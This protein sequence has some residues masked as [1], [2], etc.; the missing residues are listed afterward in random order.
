VTRNQAHPLTRRALVALALVSAL[1]ATACREG[2]SSTASAAPTPSSAATVSS[3]EGPKAGAKSNRQ[4]ALARSPGESAIDKEI[5]ALQQALE[6]GNETPDRWIVL[7]RAWVRKAREAADPGF[8]LNAKACADIALD[9]APGDRAAQNLVGLVLLNNHK[10]AEARDLADELLAKNGDDLIALGSLSDA[11]LELGHVAEAVRAADRMMN[12]KPNNP[13]Y[14]RVSF[15]KWVQGDVPGALEAIR[16]AIDSAHGAKDKEPEAWALVQ[17]AM[18]WW[19]KGDYSGA[20]KGFEAAL[21]V[22][23]DYPPALVGRGRVAMAQGDAK[24]AADLLAR[25]YAASPL[26]ETAWLLGDAREAAG[27]ASGAAAAYADVVKNGRQSDH[28]TLAAF[29]ADK[30]RDTDEAVRLIEGEAKTRGGPYVDDV[31]GW[32]LYRAGKLADARAASDRAMAAGTKDA[33]LYYHAGAIRIAAGDKA[34]GE[35]LVKDALALNP[36]FDW[37]GSAEA[38]KLVADAK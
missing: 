38:A 21:K 33:A 13:S 31:R 3:S 28:K 23:T 12:I 18:I 29:Y 9:A 22:F 14:S 2:G 35:K 4:L 1:A 32:A 25:A 30:N 27:D 11:E 24:R 26:V 8:Y 17:A 6:K 37:T 5:L 7:G 19:H 20:D 36:K 16:L 15:L 34:G 10:F